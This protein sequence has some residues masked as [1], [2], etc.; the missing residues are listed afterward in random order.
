[1]LKDV[2]L[3]ADVALNLSIRGAG[4]ICQARDNPFCRLRS[5]T[6]KDGMQVA[7]VTASLSQRT[8][9]SQILSHQSPPLQAFLLKLQAENS[10]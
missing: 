5:F 4:Q 3:F 7:Y 2:F 9:P 8:M 10:F 6:R 1:M